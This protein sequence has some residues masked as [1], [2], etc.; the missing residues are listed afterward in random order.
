MPHGHPDWGAAEAVKIVHH[1]SDMGEL[2]VRLGAISTRHRG[3]T[4]VWDDDFRCGLAGWATTTEDVGDAVNLTT[5]YTWRG[6]YAAEL[7]G[8]GEAAGDTRITRYIGTLLS[9]KL[10]LEAAFALSGKSES[11]I[12]QMGYIED[13]ILHFAWARYRHDADTFDVYDRF[14]GWQEL[15]S[16][17]GLY[18]GEGCYHTV[19]LVVDTAT[20][21]YVS[22]WL[23]N[24]SYDVS[25]YTAGVMGLARGDA[26]MVMV[27]HVAVANFVAFALIDAVIV[28]QNEP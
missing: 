2:G 28:T 5:R 26:T 10:G 25:A 18:C 14:T 3:G 17:L 20:G 13:D 4:V 9:G 21:M 22:L 19:K 15:A 27:Q 8:G 7:V 11:L 6:G 23:D 1:V 16:G 24:N 12:F